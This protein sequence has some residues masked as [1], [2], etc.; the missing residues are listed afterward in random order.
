MKNKPL[1]IIILSCLILFW[2]IIDSSFAQDPQT[3]TQSGVWKKYQAKKALKDMGYSTDLTKKVICSITINSNNE[4]SEFRRKMLGEEDGRKKYEFIELTDGAEPGDPNWFES[5]C[6]TMRSKRKQCDVLIVSGHHVAGNFY[7]SGSN[8]NLYV[9]NLEGAI[10]ADESRY[11]SIDSRSIINPYTK[12]P[13]QACPEILGDPRNNDPLD[14][15]FLFGCTTCSGVLPRTEMASYE[16]FRSISAST[17]EAR[18]L[19]AAYG[20][21]EN[22]DTLFSME[23]RFMGIFAGTPHIYCYR[24]TAPLGHVIQK[25]LRDYLMTI[26]DYA[27][28]LANQISTIETYTDAYGKTGYKVTLNPGQSKK[29]NITESV[30]ANGRVMTDL[31]TAHTNYGAIAFD[32]RQRLC[33]ERE[34]IIANRKLALEKMLTD[35][36]SP[37]DAQGQSYRDRIPLYIKF[38]DVNVVE[39][40]DEQEIALLDQIKNI[41]AKNNYWSE[42]PQDEAHL[43][44]PG[45]VANQIAFAHAL[46]WDDEQHS[47]ARAFLENVAQHFFDSETFHYQKG[48]LINKVCSIKESYEIPG[49]LKNRF[50]SVSTLSEEDQ[51]RRNI[52]LLSYVSDLKANRSKCLDIDGLQQAQSDVRQALKDLKEDEYI[53]LGIYSLE[54]YHR[55]I[56]VFKENSV[57]VSKRIEAIL[58][59]KFYINQLLITGVSDFPD[60]PLSE[61]GVLHEFCEASKE[62]VINVTKNLIKALEDTT[63]QWLEKTHYWGYEKQIQTY[64]SKVLLHLLAV[65]HSIDQPIYGDQE[66]SQCIR[67]DPKAIKDLQNHFLSYL[68]FFPPRRFEDIYDLGRIAE[69]IQIDPKIW[70]NLYKDF[71]IRYLEFLVSDDNRSRVSEF[72]DQTSHREISS[73]SRNMRQIVKEIMVP[74]IENINSSQPAYQILFNQFSAYLDIHRWHELKNDPI[75]LNA[76][77]LIN[78]PKTHWLDV[79]LLMANDL[80]WTT[81]DPELLR[82]LD[83]QL[84]S[85]WN[86]SAEDEKWQELFKFVMTNSNH[87][88]TVPDAQ[89]AKALQW[90]KNFKK[91]NPVEKIVMYREPIVYAFSRGRIPDPI[92]L[93]MLDIM[94]AKDNLEFS[95]IRMEGVGSN[96]SEDGYQ[97]FVQLLEERI[98]RRLF[99]E[100]LSW[101]KSYIVA[102]STDSQEFQRYDAVGPQLYYADALMEFYINHPE[103]VTDQKLKQWIDLE[104]SDGSESSSR[105]SWYN[106]F[107]YR[108]ILSWMFRVSR[109]YKVSPDVF[110]HIKNAMES[111]SFYPSDICVSIPRYQPDPSLSRSI[112]KFEKDY[113]ICQKPSVYL[114]VYQQWMSSTR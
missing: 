64:P 114:D 26:E 50:S 3:A 1:H 61:P 89:F 51:L 81:H 104:L 112:K 73:V 97:F 101:A 63:T 37:P 40:F 77:D 102:K 25:P 105:S 113:K 24:G 14:E 48:G 22:I 109:R 39:T 69:L 28:Y 106:H 62:P 72:F 78:I 93:E 87:F 83:A 88:F 95:Y 52:D 103:T 82:V 9:R 75:E 2:G 100:D 16:Y 59:T 15:T 29:Q 54:D 92:A 20:L 43:L 86:R 42:A 27:D 46:G 33:Q 47:S 66:V 36:Q 5:A 44:N 13:Y 98:T 11:Y 65:Q 34:S 107:K 99:E 96:P 91:A 32:H 19:A 31:R 17:G 49:L 74:E 70:K 110:A 38:F 45:F 71:W 80:V 94:L 85:L 30:V 10:C 6:Q 12:E 21:Q 90:L 18:S 4:I 67:I 41:D 84:Q 76:K 8:L 7:G 23:Q 111:N 68:R 56:R 35:L 58:F 60:K 55:I 79:A 57:M 53:D 108:S